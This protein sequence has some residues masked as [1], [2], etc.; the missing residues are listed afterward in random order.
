MAQPAD[1]GRHQPFAQIVREL[2]GGQRR[3]TRRADHEAQHEIVHLDRR[4]PGPCDRDRIARRA[5]GC[6]PRLSKIADQE[7]MERVD[8]MLND[9]G[10]EPIADPSGKPAGPHPR[11]RED[12]NGAAARLGRALEKPQ[13][14]SHA[15]SEPLVYDRE[16]GASGQP[17]KADR[18][19]TQDQGALER[20]PVPLRKRSFIH[21]IPIR[22]R[23]KKA[24]VILGAVGARQL[25]ER[26]SE[27]SHIR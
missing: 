5:R 20:P 8:V 4:R 12:E 19:E 18:F 26:H 3:L 24:A 14:R 15:P 27:P 13:R 10:D 9:F 6:R 22:I 1:Q 11:R 25:A 17:A 21:P 23:Q 2:V 7:G 16:Q